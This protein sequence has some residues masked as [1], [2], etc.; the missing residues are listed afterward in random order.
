MSVRERIVRIRHLLGFYD[1]GPELL[2]IYGG[3]DQEFCG[4]SSLKPFT[5]NGG[6]SIE[7]HDSMYRCLFLQLSLFIIPGVQISFE[8]LIAGFYI[9]RS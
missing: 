2:I 3:L 8:I 1:R 4:S 9:V 7:S 5:N 6:S